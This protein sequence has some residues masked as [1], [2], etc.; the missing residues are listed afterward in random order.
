MPVSS[1]H[2]MALGTGA[3]LPLV[4][5]IADVFLAKRSVHGS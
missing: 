5:Y 3:A 4:H 2:G 1:L